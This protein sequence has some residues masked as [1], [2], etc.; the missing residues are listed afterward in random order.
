MTTS[1]RDPIEILS[2]D[3]CWDL[4]GSVSVGRLAVDIAGQPEIY[5]INFVVDD[6]HVYFRSAAGTK[7]A[8]AV[9]SGRVAF[10]IDGY[11]PDEHVA[12]SVMVKGR[13]SLV[14]RMMEVFEAEELPLFPWVAFP[15]P[16]IVRIT[17]TEVT[18]RRFHVTD[19]VAPDDSIGWR[20]SH[21]RDEGLAVQHD[22]GEEFHPGQ[23]RLHPD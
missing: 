3:Q 2:D 21:H 22:P 16:D 5:P 11:E 10:E 12:W 14:E 13:A 20:G 18:G 6:R 4:L 1:G 19:E 15:K 23:P 8:G 17:P 9:L 7:L